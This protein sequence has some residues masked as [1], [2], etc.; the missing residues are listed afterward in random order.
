MDFETLPETER[1]QGTP[2]FTLSGSTAEVLCPLCY[3]M[4]GAPVRLRVDSSVFCFVV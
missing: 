1:I 4:S 2:C 3:L